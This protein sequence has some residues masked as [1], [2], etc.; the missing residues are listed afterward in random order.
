[1]SLIERKEGLKEL[2]RNGWAAQETGNMHPIDLD[3]V[4]PLLGYSNKGHA[5]RCI[6]NEKNG[7]ITSVFT[8]RGKNSISSSGGRPVTKYFLTVK[9]LRLWC[10]KAKTKIGNDI[11]EYV[12]DIVDAYERGDLARVVPEL[13]RNHERA[14]P[15]T[16]VKVAV[17]TGRVGTA[18]ATT[19][20][21]AATSVHVQ[22]LRQQL[23][24]KK[25][26]FEINVLDLKA[27]TEL[28]MMRYEASKRVADALGLSHR[29]R[30]RIRSK[31][32][33]KES[34]ERY[35]D[36]AAITAGPS[37]VPTK[38]K[39]VSVRAYL[40]VK[41]AQDPVLQAAES[42]IGRV[43]QELW[44]R[45]YQQ[46]EDYNALRVE[47]QKLRDRQYHGSRELQNVF[48]YPPRDH[49]LFTDA[50]ATFRERRFQKEKA[51]L[52]KRK[53]SN[54]R[55]DAKRWQRNGNAKRAGF[56]TRK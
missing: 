40:G 28:S 22:E 15:D 21:V 23:A 56:F 44:K 5:V 42:Q 8:S 33:L 45:R 34:T 11:C 9:G 41:H 17:G 24:E 30:F 13:I 2:L 3:L 19:N 16:E 1:M 39:A 46:R 50:V 20:L 55:L 53:A 10:L 18:E 25:I 37:T 6:K 32:R 36:L 43:M 4:W 29:N 26:K 27:H 54:A 7:V 52:R 47:L 51:N 48:F 12:V 49:D 31:D 38:E 14:N 35:T